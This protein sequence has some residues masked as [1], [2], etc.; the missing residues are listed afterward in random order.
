MTTTTSISGQSFGTSTNIG[1]GK[2]PQKVTIQATTTSFVIEGRITNGAAGY[3]KQDVRV[4]YASSGFSVTAAVG[5]VALRP[6]AR[7]VDIPMGQA[8]AQVTIRSS[9]LEPVA[10][11]YIYLW[12]DLP[13]LTTA[14]TLD[15]N[16]TELP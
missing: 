2:F 13:T 14:A 10:G 3:V 15:V 6:T 1:E 4:W 7:Y 11:S 9:L 5:S 16:V 8:A 12:V